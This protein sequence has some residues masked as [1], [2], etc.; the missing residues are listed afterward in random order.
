MAWH[1]SHNI[2]LFTAA[3]P[4]SGSLHDAKGL[5]LSLDPA[6]AMDL[7]GSSQFSMENVGLRAEAR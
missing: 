4:S 1:Y 5:E 7:F 6:D 3:K 2:L